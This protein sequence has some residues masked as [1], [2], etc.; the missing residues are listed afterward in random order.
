MKTFKL[1]AL[2]IVKDSTRSEEIPLV[3]G[4]IIN[5]E[6]SQNRWLIETYLDKEYEKLFS[7]FQKTGEEIHLQVT[8]SNKT[9]DPAN[10][11]AKVRSIIIME[12]HISVL[13]DGCL[14]RDRTD[15]AEVI[16]ARLIR[17]G[18]QGE[19]LL[20]EFKQELQIIRESKTKEAV[21]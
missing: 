4:L 11:R 5:K 9:N 8:I 14:I 21:K 12:E 10:M 16:L 17:K 20:K 13:L 2:S 1:V 19:A 15:L 18:L 6:D 3:D 7:S